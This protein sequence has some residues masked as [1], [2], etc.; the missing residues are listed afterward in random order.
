MKT[1]TAKIIT[2]LFIIIHDYNT[3]SGKKLPSNAMLCEPTW[4]VTRCTARWPWRTC[5]HHYSTNVSENCSVARMSW[6]LEG[7]VWS[8]SGLQTASGCRCPIG[9][10]EHTI[11]P[12]S[13]KKRKNHHQTHYQA[14]CCPD[15]HSFLHLPFLQISTAWGFQTPTSAMHCIAAGFQIHPSPNNI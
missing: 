12:H 4:S 14:Y 10:L 1:I 2:N 5:Q 7:P 13:P 8:C 15:K 11:T 6:V 9:C 3:Y